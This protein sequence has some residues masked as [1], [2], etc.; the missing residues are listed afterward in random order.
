MC[1]PVTLWPQQFLIIE[2]H[3][4]GEARD[5]LDAFV[6]IDRADVPATSRRRTLATIEELEQ[7]W[8]KYNREQ[9]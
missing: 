2:T 9:Q 7:A 6:K 3:D 4:P 8:D 5:V 1:R